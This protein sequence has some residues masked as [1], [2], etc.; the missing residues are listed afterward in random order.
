MNLHP[1][2]LNWDVGIQIMMHNVVVSVH[3]EG[4]ARDV[5]VVVEMRRKG[6]EDLH[7]QSPPVK[8]KMK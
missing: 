1:F 8:I 6:D 3:M 5:G 4:M 7:S 2:L